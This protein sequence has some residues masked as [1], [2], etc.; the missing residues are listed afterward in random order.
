MTTNGSVPRQIPV[1]TLVPKRVRRVKKRR[2][3]VAGDMCSQCILVLTEED[4]E[5]GYDICDQCQYF[6]GYYNH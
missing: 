4:I 5:S 1:F 6:A 3:P 2:E